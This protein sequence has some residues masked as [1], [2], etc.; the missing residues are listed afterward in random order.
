MV[1]QRLDGRGFEEDLDVRRHVVE[2][3]RQGQG[4][5]QRRV[6]FDQLLLRRGEVVGRGGH[7]ADGAAFGGMLREPDA[8]DEGGVGD[9]DQH[10]DASCD[11]TAYQ[12]DEFITQPV[13]QALGFARRAEQKNGMDSAGDEVLRESYGSF[14]VEFVVA[15]ERGNHRGNDAL[16]FGRV[17]GEGV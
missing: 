4:V 5:G 13:G 14:A 1:G 2:V 11:L 17:H 6:V 8:L 15:L 9:S 3:E 12:L 10:G 7:D 16:K